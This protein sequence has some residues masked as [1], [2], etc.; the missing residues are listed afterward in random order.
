MEGASSSRT[1]TQATDWLW[2]GSPSRG[3]MRR[4]VFP[5][6]SACCLTTH[7]EE[8]PAAETDV[9]RKTHFARELD[10]KPSV[11]SNSKEEK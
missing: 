11:D 10:G 3:P 5:D 4:T 8:E 1:T 2:L 6:Y 9:I 7:Q